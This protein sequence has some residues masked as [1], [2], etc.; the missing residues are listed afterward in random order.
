[1]DFQ[2]IFK[3]ITDTATALGVG[4]AVWQLWLT[5]RLA[6]TSFEDGL[7]K[8]YRKLALEIPM[9]ALL[10]VDIDLANSPKVREQ[11]YNYIDL[12]NEQAFLRKKGRIGT[13]TWIEWAEGIKSNLE[14]P[15]FREVWSEIKAA[16]PEA[17]KELRELENSQFK[18]DPKSRVFPSRFL[19]TF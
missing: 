14:Q 16:S 4:F 1:M 10:G 8:E 2:T 7:N 6:Q 13:T 17:F 15:T 11:I 12:C 9:N 18:Q 19:I 3:A 5:Q